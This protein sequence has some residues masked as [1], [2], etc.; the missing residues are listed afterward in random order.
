MIS[1]K[2]L[3]V[4][5]LGGGDITIEFIRKRMDEL[6]AAHFRL[7]VCGQMNSGKSTFLNAW[8]FGSDVL[9]AYDTTMT[10]HLTTLKYAEEPY[11]EVEFLNAEEWKESRDQ[12]ANDTDAQKE[13]GRAVHI[14]QERGVY[15]CEVIRPEGYCKRHDTLDELTQYVALPSRGGIYSIFVKEV[16]V[17]YPHPHLRSLTIVDTPGINDPNPVRSRI[18]EDYVKNADAVAYIAYAAQAFDRPDMDFIAHYL[19]SVPRDNLVVAVNKTD[20]VDDIMSVKRWT[21]KLAMDKDHPAQRFIFS[22]KQSIVYTC[23][24]AE[25][26]L[27]KHEAGQFL[28]EE[29]QEYWTRFQRRNIL[30]HNDTGFTEILRLI[31][32]RIISR[33]GQS[34][35]GSHNGSIKGVFQSHIEWLSLEIQDYEDELSNQA[36]SKAEIEENCKKLDQEIGMVEREI[37]IRRES[38]NY[39]F[40]DILC[41]VEECLDNSV[42]ET[43]KSLCRSLSGVNMN[44]LGYFIVFRFNEIWTRESRSLCKAISKIVN[45]HFDKLRIA[46][47]DFL[48]WM[49]DN[50]NVSVNALSTAIRLSLLDIRDMAKIEM[51]EEFETVVGDIVKQNSK[52][53][54]KIKGAFKRYK[55]DM[56]ATDHTMIKVREE[57]AGFLKYKVK[58]TIYK[59][60]YEAVTQKHDN[61]WKKMEDLIRLQTMTLRKR[62]ESLLECEKKTKDEID[63]IAKKLDTCKERLSEV[64]Q[65]RNEIELWNE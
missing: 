32:N 14:L 19:T 59:N 51:S 10:A 6:R 37:A 48:I 46:F 61:M 40:S 25:L 47:E 60:I 42:Q 35:L 31:E 38:L 34:I 50:L 17:F 2:L 56:K 41:D 43:E 4:K 64:E 58:D 55:F 9:P 52:L 15:E 49:C 18:T 30:S 16:R 7:C 63:E 39:S 21:D 28:T 8:I 65:Y 36:K 12:I 62:L 13:Y 44:D 26:L 3:P 11:F 23:A 45:E 5:E 29:E 53:L 22:D 1:K 24:L 20:A 54:D 27:R 33:R 57:I